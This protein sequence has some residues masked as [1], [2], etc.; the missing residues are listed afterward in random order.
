MKKWLLILALILVV[1]MV[2]LLRVRGS[3]QYHKITPSPDQNSVVSSFEECVV[4]GNPVMESYPRQCRHGEQLF[5]E[6]VSVP[7]VET[8][9][10]PRFDYCLP[11]QRDVDFCTQIYQPVC[12]RIFVQCV[13]APCYPVEETF[14]SPC[15]ACKNRDVEFFTYGECGV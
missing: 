12:A 5:V 11:E 14:S 2:S 8:E 3:T 6:E 9:D 10:P 15:E 1:L 13:K 7:P 4:V